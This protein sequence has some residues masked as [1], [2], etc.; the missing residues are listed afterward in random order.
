MSNRWPVDPRPRLSGRE[1]GAGLELEDLHDRAAG[2][3]MDD[4][5][6]RRLNNDGRFLHFPPGEPLDLRAQLIRG[7]GEQGSVVAFHGH[8]RGN[9]R[10]PAHGVTGDAGVAEEMR[11]LEGAQGTPPCRGCA[12]GL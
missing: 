9:L 1:R 5:T 6:G 4:R 7:D 3:G 2:E 8:R 10:F 11:A 12:A